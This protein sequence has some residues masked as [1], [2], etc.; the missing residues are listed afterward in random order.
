MF[1]CL[2][3][4]IFCLLL[5]SGCSAQPRESDVPA[6]LYDLTAYTEPYWTGS[7]TVNESVLPMRGEDGT[8][9]P[10]SL[11]Y[12]IEQVESVW[13]AELTQPY[14]P[15]RDYRV[16]GGKLVIPEGSAIPVLNYADLYLSELLDA[17]GFEATKSGYIYFSEGDFFHKAQLAVTYTHTAAWDGPVPAAQGTSLPRTLGK[18]EGGEPLTIVYYGDSITAGCNSSATVNAQPYAPR[19]T[20]MVTQRLSALYP[21]AAITAWND[22]VGGKDSS[23]GAEHAAQVAERRPDLV[24]I[25]FGLNDANQGARPGAFEESIRAI[26]D[27]IRAANP[28][29]E[30]ILVSPMRSNAEAWDFRAEPLDSYLRALREMTGEGVALADMTTLHTYMLTRK[31][32]RDMT[33]NNVNHPN[34]FLARAYAQVL[35]RTMEKPAE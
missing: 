26:M 22:A 28:D 31:A 14:L 29:C 9:A 5:L 18:L 24:V 3:L 2:L 13:N 1:R 16:E 10:I 20:D 23:W 27:T 8:I 33:G 15:G 4:M 17:N 25:A 6:S 11:L 34:D 35:L 32:F 12:P 19:W 21:N 30:F 7:R